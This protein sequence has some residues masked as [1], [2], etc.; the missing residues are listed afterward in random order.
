MAKTKTTEQAREFVRGYAIEHASPPLAR[1]IEA[2]PEIPLTQVYNLCLR[3]RCITDEDR[4][5]LRAAM[6]VV[7][8]AEVEAS[9]A[10]PW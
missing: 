1:S 8:L 10:Q 4:E 6:A 7:L 9:G 5:A 3:S 2:H